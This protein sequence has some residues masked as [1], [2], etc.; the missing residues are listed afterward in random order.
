MAG[1]RAK[2]LVGFLHSLLMAL[3]TKM[4]WPCVSIL[5]EDLISSHLGHPLVIYLSI[6]PYLVFIFSII[7]FWSGNL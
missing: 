2:G 6:F 3:E 7:L 1:L 5:D 4:G